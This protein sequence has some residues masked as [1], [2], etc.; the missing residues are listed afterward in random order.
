MK[1]NT[2]FFVFILNLPICYINANVNLNERDQ[3]K[4][5]NDSNES[6][7]YINKNN[8]EIILEIDGEFDIIPVTMEQQRSDANLKFE[9]QRTEIPNLLN[10]AQMSE[11]PK[12]D[13]SQ[14]VPIFINNNNHK[15]IQ[16]NVMQTDLNS[17]PIQNSSSDSNK[18]MVKQAGLWVI[19]Q[20][21]LLNNKLKIAL[22]VIGAGWVFLCVKLMH[23][24]FKVT[25]NNT[26]GAWKGNL[27]CDDLQQSD[28]N[29]IAKELFE[30]ITKKYI[31]NKRVVHF[32][33]PLVKFMNDVDAELLQLKKFIRMREML[34]FTKLAFFFPRQEEALA[35]A[36]EKI[37]RLEYLKQLL[38]KFISEYKVST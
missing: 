7:Y 26:W 17:L 32:L 34:N 30:A 36:Q 14:Q 29:I 2:I 38:T 24:S 11:I 23:I 33:N 3:N 15:I 18:S 8:Q 35:I 20:N 4:T 25:K 27:S 1:M 16:Q 13:E 6:T 9:N 28:Q 5:N 12:K 37:Q 19:S 31:G 22:G 10:Q 21:F